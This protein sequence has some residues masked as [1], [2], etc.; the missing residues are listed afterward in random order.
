MMMAA[1]Q[2]STEVSIFPITLTYGEFDQVVFDTIVDYA[3]NTNPE[4]PHQVVLS[5]GDITVVHKGQR[6]NINFIELTTTESSMYL[7]L[8]IN[9]S[10]YYIISH[11]G[12]WNYLD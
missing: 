12:I 6:N 3:R 7:G 11:R 5:S 9:Y 1:R 10:E 8:F 2:Q 4:S